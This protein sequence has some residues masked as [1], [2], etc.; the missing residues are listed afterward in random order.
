MADVTGTGTAAA[1]KV[2]EDD[3]ND[4]DGPPHDVQ[5]STLRRVPDR[6]PWV[7]LLILIVELGERFTYFG[8]SAPIQ[9]YVKYVL[10]LHMVASMVNT[11]RTD[12]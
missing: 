11:T 4:V 7:V 2:H 9:N 1:V 3:M 6:I 12:D 8:L 10:L 5:Y